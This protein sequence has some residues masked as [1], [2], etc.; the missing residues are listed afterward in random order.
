MKK[1]KTESQPEVSIVIVCMNK[2]SNLDICLP[3]I[4]KYTKT[5][6]VV[7]VVAYLFSE[8]NLIKLHEQYPWV[9]VIESNEIKGFS[10]N[11]NLALRKVTTPLAFIL[12]DDTEFKE[13]VLDKLIASLY[14]TPEATVMSPVIWNGEG[15]MLFSG[16]RKET[17]C[18]Y[19]LS[20]FL[21]YR[22]KK[23]KF[24]NGSG[25]FKTYTLSGA[26]FLIYTRAFRE[27]G[28]FNEFYFFCP[29]DV[30]VGHKLNHNNKFCY[31]DA[32]TNIIHYESVSSKKS[33]LFYA[34]TIV[35][36]LGVCYFYGN[37]KAKRFSLLFLFAYKY[38]MHKLLNFIK[39]TKHHEDYIYIYSIVLRSYFKKELPKTV[40]IREYNKIKENI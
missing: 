7:Y 14:K 26:A 19:L 35:A 23:S 4:E 34:T 20:G 3:S 36:L 2:M 6:H 1:I 29:E 27:I 30:E 18:A 31:V 22:K 12:N 24:E 38:W 8:A 10:E 16:R 25:I 37:S 15:A 17:F 32:D 5:P 13:P 9:K 40:F 28:F 33:K 11:N 21:K 39:R